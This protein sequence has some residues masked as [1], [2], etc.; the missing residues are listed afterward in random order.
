MAKLTNIV[1]RL[2]LQDYRDIYDSLEDRNAEKSAHLLKSLRERK[3]SDEHIMKELDVTPNAYYTLRSRLNQRIEE[4]LIQQ[5]ESPRTDLLKKVANIMEIAFTKKWTIA[6]ATLKKLEKE[7]I[8]YDLFN[9]LTLV[10]KILKKL[11]LHTEDYFTYSQLYNKHVAFM[12]A[13][14]KAEDVMS[15]YF[16]SYGT[17]TLSGKES[18]RLALD[19]MYQEMQNIYALNNSHRLY[20]YKNCVGVFHRLFVAPEEEQ[21]SDADHEKEPL[22]N[23]L[24][25]S[26]TIFNNYA[27]DQ[28]YFHINLVFAYL[29]FEYYTRHRLYRKS[30][31]FYDEVNDSIANFIGH[32]SWFTYPTQFLHT[33]IERALRLGKEASLAEES[34]ALFE[35]LEYD[36]EN[37]EQHLNYSVYHVLACHF[38]G[39]YRKATAW[40]NEILN[41]PTIKRYPYALVEVKTLLLVQYVLLREDTLFNQLVN[42]IQ[43]HIRLL[44]KESCMETVWIIKIC[45]TAMSPTKLERPKKIRALVENLGT[46][47]PILFAPTRYLKFSESFICK[48][49]VPAGA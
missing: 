1:R 43:R 3:V 12:L 22:E 47:S 2:S 14:D 33:K 36:K 44:G 27:K 46:K 45:K 15:S 41:T 26:S 16:K 24:A 29:R 13:V 9:E 49:C 28:T 37:F 48:L 18:D 4:H 30:E 23:I 32:Y 35:N 42:S 40:L 8:D 20:V 21:T 7:L 5:M 6:V 11:H 38:A 39:Q 25:K 31:E 19:L 34:E 10:Y 17:Y